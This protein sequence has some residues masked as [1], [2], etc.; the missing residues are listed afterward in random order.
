MKGLKRITGILFIL[1]LLGM[2]VGYFLLE[3]TDHTAIAHKV[4]GFSVLA[5]VFLVMP[6]FLYF[7]FKGKKLKDYTLTPDNI[8]RWREELDRKK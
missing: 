5:V 8:E 4:I 6:M 3:F 7:R 1:A 2:G